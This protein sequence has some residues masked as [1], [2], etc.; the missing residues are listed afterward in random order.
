M[1]PLVVRLALLAI[2]GFLTTATGCAM[3]DDCDC[4]RCGHTSEYQREPVS[5]MNP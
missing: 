1:K 5:S 4:D 2:L 3:F